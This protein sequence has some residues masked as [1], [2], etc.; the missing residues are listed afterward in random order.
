MTTKS[1]SERTADRLYSMITVEQILLPGEKLPNENILSA[2]LNV[3]RATLREAIRALAAQGI[4]TVQRGKGTF[5]SE[6]ANNGAQGFMTMDRAHMRL[7]DLYEMRLIFEP[8]C[9]ALACQRASDEEIAEICAQ[10]RKVISHIKRKKPWAESDQLFHHLIVKAAHN[11]FIIRLFP[12]INS[13]VSETMELGKDINELQKITVSD[14]ES[15]IEQLSRRDADGARCAMDLHM[16]HTI[17]AL[18]LDKG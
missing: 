14:N 16:R 6:N 11:E 2:E 5:V 17:H 4:L 1:L 9:I 8:V 7:K 13:A 12:I 3:S 15:I 18:G 10:G